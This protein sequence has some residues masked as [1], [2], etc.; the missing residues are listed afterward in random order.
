MAELFYQKN[1]NKELFSKCNEIVKLFDIQ[2]YVPLYN[3]YFSLNEINYNSINLNHK[4]SIVS[5]VSQESENIY[6]ICIQENKKV[7]SFFKFSPLLDPVKYMIGKYKEVSLEELPSKQNN[8]EN[9]PKKMLDE[10]NSS[11]VDS[12]FSYLTSKLLHTHNFSHGLDFY[13]SFL[14]IKH[15]FIY[16][17]ADDLEYLSD[18]EFFHKNNN[19]LFEIMEN[20]DD[21]FE[22]NTRNYREKLSFKKCLDTPRVSLCEI[23]DLKELDE[24]FI[25]S[26]KESTKESKESTKHNISYSLVF[27]NTN[28]EKTS[29][30]STQNTNSGSCSSKSSNTSGS[31][32][33]ETES[34]SEYEEGSEGESEIET[35][36]S[37]EY[38]DMSVGDFVGAKIKR[39]PVQMI[40]LEKMENTL[41]HYFENNEISDNEWKSILFQIIMTLV[42]YQKVFDFTHNDLHTNN[43]MYNQTDKKFL[44]YCYNGKHYKVPT[45]GKLYKIIDFGRSIY[46]F[47]GKICCS[48]SYHPKG[49]AAG[50]YNCEPYYNESKPWLEPS[51]S[52]DLCRLG[53]SLFDNFFENIEDVK[54]CKNKIA[55]LVNEWCLDEK[56]RNILYKSNGEERYENFKLYKMI[57]RTV[58]N[59]EP[60]KY[61]EHELFSDYK[62]SKKNINKKSKII[63]IDNLPLYK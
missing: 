2:N 43:I 28:R 7:Q 55:L 6:E 22:V 12:F 54:T 51:K 10:N 60:C 53:C 21:L 5:I 52:F 15:D 62:T 32:C 17:I 39:F 38:S 8:S 49:D 11:Y 4:N 20:I 13:G 25:E 57:V 36:S 19:E 16:N 59:R 3:K 41:D 29:N 46:K 34:E 35:C 14:G 1:E 30:A 18:S 33:Y 48:D 44:N 24:I 27:E 56:N 63:N 37:S 61:V 47:Q 42:T 23:N 45:F 31:S 26:E 50:Q 9:I 58:K 40:C